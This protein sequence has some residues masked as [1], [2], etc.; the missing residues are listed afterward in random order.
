MFRSLLRPSKRCHTIIQSIYKNCTYCVNQNHPMLQLISSAPLVV[1]KCQNLLIYLTFYDQRECLGERNMSMNSGKLNLSECISFCV[2]HVCDLHFLKHS[3]RSYKIK[4]N[5]KS[6]Y[7]VYIWALWR[8]A[9]RTCIFW[10]NINCLMPN[11]LER[12]CRVSPLTIKI[13]SKSMR[14]KPTNIAIIQS[15]Y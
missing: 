7:G 2:C 3:P 11:D 12:R 15:V 8:L 5:S 14:E 9:V 1:I 4:Q 10:I 13:P 6:L